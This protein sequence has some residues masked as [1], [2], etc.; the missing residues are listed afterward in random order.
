VTGNSD[1]VDAGMEHDWAAPPGT[2]LSVDV[3]NV[4]KKFRLYDEKFQS[5]KER[6][7]HVGKTTHEDFLALKD[8]NFSVIEGETVGILGRN[9]SGKSTLLKCISGILQPTTGEIRVRGHL[10]AL[11]ELGAGFQPELS[12]RD[13]IF[14]NAALLGL[15][16]KEMEKR[17]DDIVAFAELEQFIDNQ[18]KFYSSGM[19]VRLGFAVAVNVNPDVLV[20]DEVLAV[21]DENFQRKCMERIKTFQTEGRTILFVT[22]A[23]DMVRLI[24]DR[25]VVLAHGNVLTVGTPGKAIRVFREHLLEQDGMVAEAHLEP[26]PSGA[27]PAVTGR[28]V[29]I[30]SVETEHPGTGLRNYLES[31]EPLTL[32][33]A[34]ETVEATPDVVFAVA[35]Y[36]VAG[37]LLFR[38]DT[39][40][41]GVHFDAALGSGRVDF[42]FESVPL[43]DGTFFVSVGAQSGGG[44]VYDWKEQ[45]A[46]FEVMNPGRSVG[47]V[48]LPVHAEIRSAALS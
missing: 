18:V 3:V 4:S 21:G 19:Y 1:P 43:M 12:G 29:L 30:S 39:E 32:H 14:L 23:A 33:V 5:L 36:D 26:D 41:L 37:N 46:T 7:L 38:T 35:V 47:V 28:R 10:A 40:I 20:I 25:A 22:H 9:G 48:S 2:H 42:E 6:F 16:Q 15:S 27:T 45:A 11:L 17:F 8:V 31:R 44:V 34:F 24:C 13:N